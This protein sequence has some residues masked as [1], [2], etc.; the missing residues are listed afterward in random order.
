MGK[1]AIDI[2]LK[3]AKTFKLD[4]EF[5]VGDILNIHL[6]KKFDLVVDSTVLHSIVGEK[7]RKAF[8]QTAKT[9][10]HENG[11]LFINTMIS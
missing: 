5:I 8:Y 2:A 11:Y 9:H 7:D 3:N 10:L 6:N 4:V 1:T